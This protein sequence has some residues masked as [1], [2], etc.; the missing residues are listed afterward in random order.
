MSLVI[1]CSASGAPGVTTSAL[2]LAISWPGNVM[3]VDCDRDPAQAVEAG[4][5]R[6]SVLGA[7]GL[8]QVARAHRERRPVVDEVLAQSVT[9]QEHPLF[10]RRFLPGFTHPG[11]ANV[12][13]PVWPELAAALRHVGD[14]DVDVLIDA[15]RI[16]RD[17]LPAALLVEADLVLV[18]VRSSLRSLAAARLHLPGLVE[19]V[20]MLSGHAEVALAV[21]GASMPYSTTEISAQFASPV[22]TSIAFHPG[23]ARVLSDGA[24]E[25]R[26]FTEGPLMRSYR[27][28]STAISHQLQRRASVIETGSAR[29]WRALQPEA[30]AR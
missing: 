24:A 26:R 9:L 6:G 20:G 11:S 15:G 29:D 3:L 1:C 10:T 5:L 16:G 17:G 19:H 30:V 25:P 12:F 28:A 2:G 27:T 14:S 4:Y 13:S 8:A 21:V 23:H 22:A 7:R 18:F